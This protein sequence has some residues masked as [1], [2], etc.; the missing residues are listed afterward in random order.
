MGK[1]TQSQRPFLRLYVVFWVLIHVASKDNTGLLIVLDQPSKFHWLHPLK[2]FT[3]KIIEEYL[4]NHIFHVYGVPEVFIS[5]NGS[6]FKANE[7][8]AFLTTHGVKHVYTAIYTPQSNAPERF[9]RSIIAAIRAYLKSDQRE[10]D[11]NINAISCALRN[12]HHL[13]IGTSAYHALYGYD[14]PRQ[15]I[16][17]AKKPTVN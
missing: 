12:G 11:L 13:S 16:P 3:S 7:L 14:N 8:N 1:K 4:Q 10:W 5:N 17:I 9:N 2:K 15:S 6:Q